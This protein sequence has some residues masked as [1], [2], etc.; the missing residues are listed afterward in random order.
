MICMLPRPIFRAVLARPESALGAALLG[1]S[2]SQCVIGPGLGLGSTVT[3]SPIAT[4]M[5][6][7]RFGERVK[8]HPLPDG[9]SLARI[10]QPSIVPPTGWLALAPRAGTVP[11]LGYVLTSVSDLVIC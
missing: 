1:Y 6:S 7:R 4:P 8:I 9:K 10:R 11:K 2:S 3:S 5:P